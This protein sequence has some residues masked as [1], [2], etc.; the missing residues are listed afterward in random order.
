MANNSVQILANNLA[1]LMCQYSD[2]QVMLAQ[3]TQLSQKSISNMLNPKDGATPLLGNVELVANAYHMHAWQLI[4]EQPDITTKL[5]QKIAKLI[6]NYINAA[7]Q[8]RAIIDQ[9]AASPELI[10]LINERIRTIGPSH[11]NQ[12]VLV[13]RRA[14]QTG[15]LPYTNQGTPIA[16]NNPITR[17]T[18]INPQPELDQTPTPRTNTR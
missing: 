8:N 13:E 7:P 9:I 4:I 12:P 10:Q 2:T 16:H 11:Q 3:K 15:W 14:D 17:K 5:S 1:K 18:V 6:E